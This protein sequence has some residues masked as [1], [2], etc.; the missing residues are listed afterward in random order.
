MF[1]KG[2][3]LLFLGFGVF[4]LMQVVMPYLAFQGWE[5]LAFQAQEILADPKPSGNVLGVEIEN[6]DGFSAFVVKNGSRQAPYKMFQLSIPALQLNSVK[7]MVNSNDFAEN[8]S[9][10][11]G[12]VF[13]GERGN[14]FIT[15]H[16]SLDNPVLAKKFA[17]FIHL[18]DLK[19][20]DEVILSALGQQYKYLVEGMRIVD[21]KDISV[22]NPPDNNGRYLTLMTCVPPGFSTR[23][24]I[25]LAK[26]RS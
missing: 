9:H 4:I 21:P 25:V 18:Q 26:I 15:G 22:V 23:R 20:G 17:Y 19:K 5:I 7:V 11:P 10:L 1:I 6:S 16:S 12:S 14:I 13:P 24:L 3:S 8:L 2:L